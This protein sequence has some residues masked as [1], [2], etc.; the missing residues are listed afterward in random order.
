MTHKEKYHKKKIDFDSITIDKAQI[1]D[2]EPLEPINFTPPLDT[3]AD[4]IYHHLYANQP[5]LDLSTVTMT[6]DHRSKLFQWMFE[7]SNELRLQSSTIFICVYLF[8]SFS[9]KLPLTK[10]G[11]FQ[12]YMTAALS[13]AIKL[14]QVKPIEHSFLCSW[15]D[16]AFT[17]RELSLAELCLLTTLEYKCSVPTVEYFLWY[18]RDKINSSVAEKDT[19]Y[20]KAKK[21]LLKVVYSSRYAL[22]RPSDLALAAIIH[23]CPSQVI[24]TEL[25]SP[26]VEKALKFFHKFFLDKHDEKIDKHDEKHNLF[27][28]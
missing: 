2:V 20:Q 13:I 25:M 12:L 8:D 7:V 15:S 22:H 17:P 4:E 23:V 5:S 6:R 1:D 11:K 10:V 19:V 27:R 28:V 24:S 3:T 26:L 9:A 18:H 16:G 14:N 21:L